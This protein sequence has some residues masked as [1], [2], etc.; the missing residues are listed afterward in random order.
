MTMTNSCPDC[1]ASIEY[2]QREVRLRTGVCPSCTKEFAFL[3]G[4]TVSSRLGALPAGAEPETGA[5]ASEAVA[6][7]GGPECDECGSPLAFREGRDGS[8]EVICSECETTTVFVPKSEAAPPRR[9]RPTRFDEDVPRGRPCRKCGAPLRFSTGDDGMLV[10]ECEACGNRFTLPPRPE[11]GGG[12]RRFGGNPRYGRP[13]FR[14][15]PGGRPPYR[16]RGGSRDERPFR[17]SDRP[18]PPRYD[19]EDRRRKRRRPP[20]DE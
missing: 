20:R 5:R 2:E 7:E 17:R 19:S 4:A 11:G 9:E 1:G 3:E 13:D 16:G 18:G 15:G 6:G 14:R 12:D 10:G 8:L